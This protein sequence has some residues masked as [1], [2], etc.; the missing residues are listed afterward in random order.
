MYRVLVV[1]D[2][3]WV[4]RGLIHRIP[5]ERLGLELAGEADD[6]ESA[7]AMAVERRPHIAFID[8]RMPGWDGRE[9]LR[10]FHDLLPELVTIVLSGY[11]DFEYTQ[12]AVRWKAFDYLL[13]PVKEPELV[14]SLERAIAEAERRRKG[15]PLR[16]GGAAAL[17]AR[18]ER[19]SGPVD[20][21]ADAAWTVFAVRR[22]TR[23]GEGALR[24][25]EAYGD[26]L[27]DAAR[28][29]PAKVR[30]A[31]AP[32]SA[33]GSEV[34]G[35]IEHEVGA[36][37]SVRQLLERSLRALAR[38][39]I[40]AS[41]GVAPA[42][43]EPDLLDAA[44]GEARRLL[45][46]KPLNESGALLL[47][48]EAADAG[49]GPGQ[50]AGA[51]GEFTYPSEAEHRFLTSL[52]SGSVR[53][54][55]TALEGFFRSL[56]PEKTTMEGL[57]R[58]AETLVYAVERLLIS[59]GTSMEKVT[60]IAPGALCEQIRRC[61]GPEGVARALEGA[62]LPALSRF[63]AAPMELDGSA[64]VREVIRTIEHEYFLPLTLRGLA[65]RFHMHPDYLSRLFKRETGQNFVDYLTEFRLR[66]SRELIEEDRYKNYEIAAMVG[67]DD[68]RYFSQVFKK[69]LGMT[70]NEY[71]AQRRSCGNE[72]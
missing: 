4:R 24:L 9:L 47:A 69:K 42:V 66:K 54:A 56:P 26:S 3:H 45:D 41:A 19:P 72:N 18:L 2:E 5:W 40:V 10:R 44:L 71:R 30:W 55:R 7:L 34:V 62:W 35:L 50:Q 15:A 65:E 22:D 48:E 32:T 6:G 29:T 60:G 20:G 17:L 12:A 16:R 53:S 49:D 11:S 51:S 1:D 36:E 23:G 37:A 59:N 64:V 38:N 31:L 43:T 46:A 21:Q 68:Y 57:R 52:R 39:R 28:G 25:P 63:F 27:S 33:D 13:K 67:Y 58:V 14:A 8:M 70:I 61:A